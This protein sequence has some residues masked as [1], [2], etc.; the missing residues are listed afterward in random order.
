[1][2]KVVLVMFKENERRDFPLTTKTTTLGRQPDCALRIPTGDVSRRHC[3]I[4]VGD[5]DVILKDLRSSNGTF[6]N[7]ERVAE[8][9]LKAGDK[10][11]VGPVTFIVQINGMPAKITPKDAV[12][13]PDVPVAVG[14][15]EKPKEPAKP[16]KD[17]D[18]EDVLDLDE[19]DFEDMFEDEDE[20]EDRGKAPPKKK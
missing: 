13:E 15:V 4:T 10:L 19:F 18:E 7:G 2:M 5:K 16:R 1:M 9:K 3:E 14:D 6:V 20:E 8:A 17:D 12:L 11:S